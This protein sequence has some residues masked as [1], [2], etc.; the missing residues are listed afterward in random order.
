MKFLPAVCKRREKIS[1]GKISK[2]KLQIC[3]FGD[4]SETASGDPG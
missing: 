4:V 1:F 3:S 2:I